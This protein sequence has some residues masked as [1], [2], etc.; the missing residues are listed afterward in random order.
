MS[1]LRKKQVR[2]PNDGQ[3]FG[4]AVWGDAR[5]FLIA[6]ATDVITFLS[7]AL[8]LTVVFLVLRLLTVL[9]YSAEH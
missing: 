8:G 4:W 2:T 9:G 5:P 3:S 6:I 1:G 7:W